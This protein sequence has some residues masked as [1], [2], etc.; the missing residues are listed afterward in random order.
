MINRLTITFSIA[1]T[2]LMFAGCTQ[3]TGGLNN[4]VSSA[5]GATL[6]AAPAADLEAVVLFIGDG[7]G[8]ST[9]TAGRIYA[10]Q[11]LG[12]TG[13]E[14]LLSFE[15]FPDVALVKTYNTDLQVPD[16]A[17]TMSAIVTGIKTRGGVLSIAPSAPRG[18][19]AAALAVPVI[20]LLEKMER[21]GLRTGV[22]STATITHATPAATYAHS[23]D[24]NWESD[25]EMPAD[26]IAAGCRDI[27]SQLIEF[28]ANTPGSDGV[29]VILG[30][31]RAN[32]FPA[33][34]ADAEYPDQTGNRK[35][36]RDLTAEWLAG[37]ADRTY[38]WNTAQ[39][40]AAATKP[41]QVFGLFEPS[42]MQ[43]NAD[44]NR[45]SDGEPSLAAM[46]AF[47]IKRL[48]T[49]SNGE[50]FLLIV[51]A[52]RIDHAHHF[53][54][55]YRAL[56]DTLALDAAVRQATDLL[57][58]NSL[59]V[60]TADHSHTFTISGYP[61]RGNPMLGLARG[62]D[63]ELL[64]DLNGQPYTTLGYANGSSAAKLDAERSAAGGKL[65]DL[66]DEVVATKDYQQVS[67]VPMRAETHAGEDVSAYAIGPGS[68]TVRGVMEQNRLFDVLE[69]VLPASVRAATQ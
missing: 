19:C 50:P 41:G 54:N 46:T 16:S 5:A 17:G 27:A 45:G 60:V 56:E 42:H 26:A 22:V 63:D 52:G 11:K 51:E 8:V 12:N 47:A 36:G 62:T 39:F 59:V 66:T 21:S 13:E 30:G 31:G 57:G 1:L 67:A 32:F 38:V 35:D 2:S 61:K 9:V 43:F 20:T 10:G 37:A 40:E 64:T 25:S 15:S 44:R 7:M 18:D 68:R 4:A 6:P 14:H 55:A 48:Q 53:N 69:S 65:A 34:T 33:A 3:V 29:D 58:E 24:R 23:A 28:A 49:L